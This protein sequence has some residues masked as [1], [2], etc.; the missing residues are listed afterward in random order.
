MRNIAKD[1][2][3]TLAKGLT[4][5]EALATKGEAAGVSE[6]S[7]SCRLTKSSTHRLLQT[8]KRLGYVRQGAK[9]GRY[10]LTLKLWE[11]GSLVHSRIDLMQAA[12]AHIGHLAAQTAETVHL[13]ILDDDDVIYLD[14]IDSSQPVRAYSRKGGRAPSYCVATGKVLLAYAA[15]E[16]QRRVSTHCTAF[17]PTTLVDRKELMRTL[18]K[19]R[20]QGFAY[21]LGEWRAGVNGLAAPIRD[22][23]GNVVAAVGVSGPAERLGR[24]RLRSF[25][26][27][28]TRCASAVSAELGYRS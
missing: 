23:D 13:S 16:V 17:T 14:K 28:V 12:A 25:V 26:P 21:N 24:A 11:L 19:I 27:V 9:G 18:E 6:L 5:V 3:R 1:T 7:R 22:A 20:Q 4:L 15:P 2:D 8:L 10:A